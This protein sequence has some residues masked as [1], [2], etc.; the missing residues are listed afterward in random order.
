MSVSR[1]IPDSKNFLRAWHDTNLIFRGDV[2]FQN[3]NVLSSECFDII[4]SFND[5]K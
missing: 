4:V 3:K 1:R 2:T 5:L